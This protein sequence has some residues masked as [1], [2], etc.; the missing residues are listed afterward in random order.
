LPL[1]LLLSPFLGTVAKAEAASAYSVALNTYGSLPVVVLN[2]TL[3]PININISTNSP[4]YTGTVL[5]L[6]IGLPGV[7]YAQ[8]N[9]TTAT[10]NNIANPSTP[11]NGTTSASLMPPLTIV[12]ADNS[13]PVTNNN[14]MSLFTVFPSWSM[15]RNFNHVQYVVLGD[16]NASYGAAAVPGN[17]SV[18]TGYP[19]TD[20][21]NAN[22][23]NVISMALNAGTPVVTSIN[24][25]LLAQ[26]PATYSININSA[27]GLTSGSVNM[28]QNGSSILKAM[29]SV[30]NIATD[31]ASCVSGDPLAIAD[32]IAGIPATING[33]VTDISNNSQSTNVN[34]AT[35]NTAP[36]NTSAVNVTTTTPYPAKTAGILV[37]ASATFKDTNGELLAYYMGSPQEPF[38]PDSQSVI[39]GVS[40]MSI[41]YLP[42]DQQNYI[43]V[44]TWRQSPNLNTGSVLPNSADT[45]FVTVLNEGVYTANQVQ[46]YINNPSTS[47]TA[48]VLQYKPT[49]AQ[50]QDTFKI[51]GILTALSKNHPQDAKTIIDLFGMHG[52]YGAIKKDPN[53][54]RSLNVELKTI[55][56][57]HKQELPAIEQ[58]LTKLAQKQ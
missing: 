42:L 33:I 10:F 19:N 6:A 31:I 37:S 5:P 36:S 30:L 8:N 4:E 3:S 26:A 2:L 46:Q 50:A 41:P 9:G 53:A 7:Y 21:K 13:T 12:T 40:S 17:Y 25:D 45:L 43:A 38:V 1:I 29:H 54:L 23:S 58:Y 49:K 56:E 32:F 51:L 55:F 57:K 48:G 22:T 15:G 34:I 35:D 11:V 18:S 27:G 20:P 39:Y 47:Q 44:T 24:L 14:W 16:L 28:P 52:K